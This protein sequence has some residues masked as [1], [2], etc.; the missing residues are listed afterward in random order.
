MTSVS[1][2]PG[3]VSANIESAGQ[4]TLIAGTKQFHSYDK[5]VC[6]VVRERLAGF[7]YS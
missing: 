3:V 2:R 6:Q 4:R 7:T 5:K 1:S